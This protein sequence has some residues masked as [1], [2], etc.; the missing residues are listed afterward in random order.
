M[1][2]GVTGAVQ[3]CLAALA[4]PPS[5]QNW[6]WYDP[7]AEI[8]AHNTSPEVSLERAIVR[9][10]KTSGRRDWSNQVPVASGIIAG[11]A[12]SRRAIDLVH[13]TEPNRFEFVELK[14][15]SDT[16][17]YA[18]VEI[19]QYGFIWLLS[20]RYQALLGYGGR[21]IVDA[22]DIRLSVLAPADYYRG[23]DLS[24][25]SGALNEGL[26]SLGER[27]DVQLEFAFEQF[28]ARFK[29]PS[30]TQIDVLA[31]LDN[32]MPLQPASA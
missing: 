1:A 32:R 6:R 4:K 19:L 24:W 2:S 21:T 7:R 18:A 17:L 31:A 25:L 15:G 5:I 20:R 30:E 26:R 28:P 8:A 23:L 27:N 11:S 22:T 29:W 3:K 12:N 16:P 14:I 13:S 9:D 10:I